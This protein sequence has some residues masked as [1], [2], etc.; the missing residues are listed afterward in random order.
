[1]SEKK[2]CKR[3]LTWV[4]VIVMMLTVVPLNVLAKDGDK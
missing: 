4:L 1:M 2:S 3:L